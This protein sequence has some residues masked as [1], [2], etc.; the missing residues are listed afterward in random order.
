MAI[1]F[2]SRPPHRRDRYRK[3]R[4]TRVRIVSYLAVMGLT[5]GAACSPERESPPAGEEVIRDDAG[6]RVPDEPVERIVSL[7]PSTTE[8]LFA[9]GAGEK[10]V[11]R[12]RWDEYPPAA[13]GVP[14]VGE[15]IDP[16]LEAIAARDPDIVVLY[17]S[18]ANQQAMQ[19]LAVLGIRT[20]NLRMDSLGSVARATRILGRVAGAAERG[21]SLATNFAQWLDSAR[22]VA[23]RG[24]GPGVVIVSWDNPPI[25]I[26]GESFLSEL[27]HL[28]GAR[29]VFADVDAPSAQVTIEAVADRDPD[30]LL[31]IGESDAPPDFFARPEWRVIDAVRDRRIVHARGSA[32][33]WPSLRAPEAVARLRDLLSEAGR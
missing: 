16:N 29:N 6:R 33:S 20:L 17:P 9:V 7:Q 1:T 25:V 31:Y 4:G 12:S 26:G 28:A 32:F 13:L 5:G 21:D 14:S 2:R 30:L 24:T 23:V 10:V 15:A 18:N 3:V 19:R 8:L 22:A 11:G 27:L